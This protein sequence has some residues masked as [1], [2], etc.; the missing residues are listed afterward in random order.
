MNIIIK[1]FIIKDID[2]GGFSQN[3]V[4]LRL[5]TELLVGLSEHIIKREYDFRNIE[6]GDG[7]F[8]FIFD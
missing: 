6:F 8:V 1:D 4:F 2:I 7:G 5:F 3:M